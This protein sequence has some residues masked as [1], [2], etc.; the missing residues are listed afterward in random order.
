LTKGGR[1]HFAVLMAEN[2]AEVV[3]LLM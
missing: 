1:K 3:Q 2:P